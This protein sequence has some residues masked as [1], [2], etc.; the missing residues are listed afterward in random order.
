MR[1]ASSK[2]LMES[3]GTVH[4]ST[5]WNATC[6]NNAS[7]LVGKPPDPLRTP[8][9]PPQNP[10]P[11]CHNNASALVGLQHANDGDCLR[12]RDAENGQPAVMRGAG[13]A[14]TTMSVVETRRRTSQ[15]GRAKRIVIR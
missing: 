14:G 8:S 9:K 1:G 3:P 6:H 15:H 10:L 11:T 13:D 5:I 12:G 2:L 4:E 7:A